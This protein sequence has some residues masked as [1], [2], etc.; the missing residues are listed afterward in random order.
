MSASFNRSAWS[1]AGFAVG[2]EVRK[3]VAENTNDLSGIIFSL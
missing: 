2:R 3:G 1:R